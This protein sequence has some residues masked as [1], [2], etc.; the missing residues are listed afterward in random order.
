VRYELNSGIIIQC[1]D[2]ASRYNR[3]AVRVF[4]NGKSILD[5]II[6]KL[7][8]L[9]IPI[10]I[11][12]P[13]NSS[14]TIKIAKKYRN[15]DLFLRENNYDDV[16]YWFAKCVKKYK[17]DSIYR[18]CADNPFIQLP[19]IYPIKRFAENE[20]YDYVAY[21]DAMIRHEGFFVE[22]VS[23]KAIQEANTLATDKTDRENVTSFIYNNPDK[24]NIYELKIPEMLDIIN[25]R[26]TV[27]TK[28]DFKIARLVYKFVGEQHWFK[29]IEF[30]LSQPL[31][32]RDMQTNIMRNPK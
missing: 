2:Y 22:F 27:D 29:I 30:C 4:H 14:E 32:L 6:K 16:L 26:L 1:R 10:I 8:H 31:I 3:K 28:D 23:A 17:F 9:E 15:V 12:T 5:I 13:K 19:L 7:S 18:I 11:N 25:I 21:K 20:E 24:F